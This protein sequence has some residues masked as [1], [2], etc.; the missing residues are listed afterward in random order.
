MTSW[1]K[2]KSDLLKAYGI[3]AEVANS[4]AARLRDAEDHGH[5]ALD[6]W[7][8]DERYRVVLA[9]QAQM[10]TILEEEGLAPD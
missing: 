8:L 7:Y 2:E 6:V 10:L 9:L 5:D 1:R 4:R 3:I